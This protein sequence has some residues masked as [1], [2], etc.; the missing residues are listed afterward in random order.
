MIRSLVTALSIDINYSTNSFIYTLRKVPI[1]KDLI[2]EDIYNSK[3]IKKI[4][5]F[6]NFCFYL[7]KQGIFKGFYF[8]VIYY[9]SSIINKNYVATS[10]THIFFVFSIIG[11]FINYKLLIIDNKKYFQLVLFNNDSKK[12]M[13]CLLLW[14]VFLLTFF[15]IIGF[16]IINRFINIGV[17]WSTLLILFNLFC[18]VCGEAF[19]I[20][21]CNDKGYLWHSNLKVYFLLLGVL[22]L[23]A[24]LPFFGIFI[25]GDILVISCIIFLILFVISCGYLFKFSNY[26]AIFKRL[27]INKASNNSSN[28]IDARRQM[29]QVRDRD[30]N[31]SNKKISGKTGYDLFNTIFFERH[32]SLL[33]RSAKNFSYVIVGVVLVLVYLIYRYYDTR[34]YISSFLSNRLGWFVIIMFFINRGA[35]I[36]QAMFYNCDHAML[37]YNFY[38]EPDV[39]LGVFKKRLIMVIKVNLIPAITLA[40]GIIAL[41]LL[42]GGISV[43]NLITIPLFIIILSV[44]FSVYYL[45]TYYL[46]QPYDRNMKVRKLSYTF[47]TLIMYFITYD[48]RKVVVSSLV[49]SIVGIIVTAIYIIVSLILVYRKAP[50]T[51]KL[52]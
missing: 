1:F 10:F 24:S 30:I 18:R 51:F 45:V 41:M 48:L 26:K 7:L 6:F 25:N 31:I 13:R 35:V 23:G 11:L 4:F 43:I 5:N 9:L 20:K 28:D 3:V 38:R 2:S 8:F 34:Y 15:N 27:Y 16:V 49:F 33:L 21:F 12:Y 42:V 36:T 39:I 50:N 47:I 37:N 22:L 32:K 17:F 40:L 44:F 29:V 14:E 52:N 19:C 46:F